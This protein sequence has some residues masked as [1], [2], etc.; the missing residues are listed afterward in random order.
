MS[1]QRDELADLIGARTPF[2]RQVALAKAD[3]IIAAGWVHA[4]PW[5]PD[6]DHVKAHVLSHGFVMQTHAKW[7]ADRL[8]ALHDDHG[9]VLGK[10]GCPRHGSGG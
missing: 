10:C 6:P 3:R 4:P 5:E 9:L 7:A 8:R 1:T 2:E